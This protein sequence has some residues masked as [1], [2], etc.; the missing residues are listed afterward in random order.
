MLISKLLAFITLISLGISIVEAKT[1]DWTET[2]NHVGEFVTVQ[3][4][5]VRTYNSKKAIYLNFHKDYKSH[6]T[7]IIFA[8]NFNKF[9]KSPDTL[10]K[11]K[12]ISVTGKIKKYK[13]QT[14]IIVKSPDDIKILEAYEPIKNIEKKSVETLIKVKDQFV[15]KFKVGLANIYF[16]A[17]LFENNIE[18]PLFKKM[19]TPPKRELEIEF[20]RLSAQYLARYIKYLDSDVLVI[21]ESPNDPKIVEKFISEYLDDRYLV[22]HNAPVVKNK[23]YYYNQQVMALVDRSKFNVRKYEA[24]NKKDITKNNLLYPFPPN[25][26]I[27]YNGKPTKFWWSR[28]PIEFDVSLKSDPSHWYKFI[29]TYPKSKFA[30]S[31][32]QALKARMQNNVHQMMLRERVEVVSKDFEDIFILGDMNDSMGMDEKEKKL[33]IDSLSTLYHGKNDSIL[34]DSVSYKDKEGTYVYKGE[35]QVIDFIF[36]SHG[37]KKGKGRVK[38]STNNFFHFFNTMIKHNLRPRPD[39]LENREL[40]LSDHA[41]VVIEV[42]H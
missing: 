21:C 12:N 41:P 27:D 24:L 38:P 33:G 2:K 15:D 9:L 40:F 8:S 26:T 39:R 25:K 35:A 18:K 31:D 13:G 29:A 3:G 5:V 10:F 32:K 34:W 16:S 23:K 11:G 36:T 7:A 4:K 28:F 1:I 17:A 30:R 14:E 6:F 42:K 37:L 19:E 20:D 22:V